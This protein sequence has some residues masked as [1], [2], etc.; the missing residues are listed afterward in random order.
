[1]T[2]NTSNFVILIARDVKLERLTC[3]KLLA[4]TTIRKSRKKLSVFCLTQSK[5]SGAH[6]PNSY[7][8]TD[9]CANE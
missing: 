2:A 7:Q 1:V 9:V 4:A 5:W 6:R 3:S 8:A